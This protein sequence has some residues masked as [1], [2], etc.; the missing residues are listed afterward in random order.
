M[1]TMVADMACLPGLGPGASQGRSP[2][3]ATPAAAG[4]PD[5]AARAREDRSSGD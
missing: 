1:Q 2:G 4:V 5:A 3:Q